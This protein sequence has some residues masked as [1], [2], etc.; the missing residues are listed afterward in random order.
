MASS[1]NFILAKR[2]AWR[3]PLLRLAIIT[4][5]F[6]MVYL[7]LYITLVDLRISP[8]HFD[9]TWYRIRFIVLLSASSLSAIGLYSLLLIRIRMFFEARSITFIA[10]AS[11]GALTMTSAIVFSLCAG[12]MVMVFPEEKILIGGD[13]LQDHTVSMLAA[14]SHITQGVFSTICSILFLYSIANAVGMSSSTFASEMFLNHD[15]A[16][17]LIIIILCSLT[18]GCQIY[19]AIRSPDNYVVY[20][21]YYVDAWLFPL[22]MYTFLSTS[23]VS[24]KEIIGKSKAATSRYQSNSVG[25]GA[26]KVDAIDG[27]DKSATSS[28]SDH[29]IGHPVLVYGGNTYNSTIA[30]HSPVS[31]H[32]I[33]TPPV[34]RYLYTE[35]VSD[36]RGINYLHTPD[37]AQKQRQ[38]PTHD[39]TYSPPDSFAHPEHADSLST[40]PLPWNATEYTEP[41]LNPQRQYGDV[42]SR[43]GVYREWF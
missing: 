36:T 19:N 31:E 15:G 25:G 39:Y 30:Q 24:A 34:P 41:S 10:L 21:S 9:I 42:S 2:N 43:P 38:Y 12:Y 14:I 33:R 40:Q 27:Q 22:E 16:R 32:N 5:L 37:Q 3:T 6:I 17:F 18:A 35:G 8:Y 26:A 1:L 28:N 29:T 4:W 20:L 23:Y 7:S 11:L 13:V